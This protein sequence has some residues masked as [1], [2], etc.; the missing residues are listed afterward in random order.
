MIK[1]AFCGTE[2]MDNLLFCEWCGQRLAS[3]S[4]ENMF[5]P[6]VANEGKAVT[7]STEQK[8]DIKK[9]LRQECSNPK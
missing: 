4:I 8:E 5:T 2:N 9:R 7:I 6:L 1:C 3:D